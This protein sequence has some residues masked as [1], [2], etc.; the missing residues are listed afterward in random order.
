MAQ[1]IPDRGPALTH[2]MIALIV[3][4]D[5]SVFLRFVSRRVAK[6][7]FGYDDYMAVVAM[8]GSYQ[9]DMQDGTG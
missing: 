3:L 2:S 6:A 9:S 1:D 8:V 7:G 4:C 5:V